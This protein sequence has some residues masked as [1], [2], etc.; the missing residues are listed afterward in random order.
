MKV[1]RSHKVNSYDVDRN[2]FI[3]PRV[4]VKLLQDAATDHSDM[5]GFG[6]SALKSRGKAWVLYQ[7]GL[8]LHRMPALDDE[9]RIQSWHA[10]E[11]QF[12]A[13][14]DYL[15]TCNNIPLVTARGVWLMIERQQNKLL[16]L[17]DEKVTEKYTLEPP[18]FDEAAF[19]AWNPCL[20]LDLTHTCPIVLRPSDFDALGHVNNTLYFE[21]LT[22]L[23]HNLIGDKIRF[24]SLHIQYSKEIPA[25][26]KE[27]EAGFQQ[28]G[29]RYLFKFFSGK[30]MH[31]VGDFQI[32]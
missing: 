18:I 6:Y 17:K 15:V 30:V 16:L 9:I 24:K 3:R 20:M 5:A 11:K 13:Y 1:E 21:Y 10:K 27:I 23:I 32:D 22:I 31:A 2:S 25:G 14:R 19:D 12:M 8:H 26:T 4:L 29:D 28:Q 7:M